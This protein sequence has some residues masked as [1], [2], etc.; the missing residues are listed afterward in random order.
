MSKHYRE[1][2]LSYPLPDEDQKMIDAFVSCGWT[3]GGS[4]D[5]NGASKTEALAWKRNEPAVV[6]SE[7]Q[8]SEPDSRDG[9]SV[10][11]RART[12]PL[13]QK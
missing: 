3:W 12:H 6:P 8:I 2:L 4:F 11:L 7:Y 9:V 1:I 10:T 5:Y 13:D